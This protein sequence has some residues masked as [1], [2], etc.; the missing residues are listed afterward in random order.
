M[1]ICEICGRD[2]RKRSRLEDGRLVCWE[3]KNVKS[4]DYEGMYK[5][6]FSYWEYARRGWKRAEELRHEKGIKLEKPDYKYNNPVSAVPPKEILEK[7][8]LS[9]DLMKYFSDFS[10]VL[11]D[12]YGFQGPR[13]LVSDEKLSPNSNATY[14]W[15]ENTVYTPKKRALKYRT[16][17]HEIWHALERHGIVPHNEDS[18]KNAEIYARACLRRLGKDEIS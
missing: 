3:C 11:G 4:L 18:E 13:Y 2:V 6:I 12:Y 1:T 16:A 9:I 17:F 15:H 14:Y 5:R 10:V 8:I 7:S